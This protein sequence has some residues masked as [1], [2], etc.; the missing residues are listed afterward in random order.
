MKRAVLVNGV[1][2]SGKTT[3]ARG[4]GERLGVPVLALDAVKEV[5][6]DELGHRDAEREWGRTLNRASIG[7]IWSLLAGF[8]PDAVV[9]VEAWF[10]LPPHDVVLAGLARGGIGRWAEVWCHASP[11]VLV[12]R[13]RARA[14]H[15]GHPAPEDYVDEL[16]RLATI[17][18]PIGTAPWLDVDT[19]DPDRVDLDAVAAWARTALDL[20]GDHR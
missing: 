10:R 1:P 6:F 20:P 4:I 9:V 19:T 7:A 8:P 16:A 15:P 17:A 11:E 13:Y 5:L 14:R 18:T 2:A 3:V 12:A